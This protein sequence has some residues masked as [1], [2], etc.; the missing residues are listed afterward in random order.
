MKIKIAL[1]FYLLSFS[2]VAQ[3]IT[4]RLIDKSSENPIPYAN[5]KTGKYSGVIS[6]EDGFF[7]ISCEDNNKS[8]TISCIGYKNKSLTIKDI[9]AF[10]YVIKLQ[11]A[12]N[13]LD[14]VFISNKVP[15]ADSIIAKVKSKLNDNY[16]FNLQQYTMFKRITDHVDFKSL[17]FE[18]DKASNVKKKQ[19]ENVNNNLTALAN[20]VK[21]SNLIQFSDIKGTVFTL[22][23]DSIK[24]EVEKAT[25]LLDYENDF[26][27]DNIQ[28]KM[29]NIILT[30]LDTTK[31]YKLKT[32]LFKIEDSLALNDE[33]FKEDN[34]NEYTVSYLNTETKSLLKR[35]Q[36]YNNAFLSKLLNSDLYEYNFEDVGYNNGELTYLI[37]LKKEK[38]N[39][40]ENFMLQTICMP[41]QE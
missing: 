8:I 9:K 23:K 34:K 26:S 12:I 3:S 35:A 39:T 38:L 1:L 4:V 33:N 15:N 40:Q 28:E 31:T 22:N 32:G 7:T 17:E 16:N 30:Y 27:I 25:E 19:L 6:N 2:I 10:N 36:F 29:Q 37:F 14:E 13:Q 18:I 20:Q 21:N 5:I 24:L 11:E 41:L